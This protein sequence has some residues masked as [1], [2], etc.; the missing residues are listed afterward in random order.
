M[1]ELNSKPSTFHDISYE[2]VYN[3]FNTD[4]K[5]VSRKFQTPHLYVPIIDLIKIQ[6]HLLHC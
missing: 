3:L 5:I 6:F 1:I 2:S 4:H